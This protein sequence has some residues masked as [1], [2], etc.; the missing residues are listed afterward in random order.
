MLSSITNVNFDKIK[1]PFFI[2]KPANLERRVEYFLNNFSGETLYAVKA[3]PSNFILKKLYEL[4]IKSFDVAS[5]NEIILVKTLFEDANIYFMNAIKPRYAISEAYFKYDV[6]HFSL[7]TNDELEKILEST[8]YANDL[9]LHLRVPVSN[10][11]SVIKL[12]EKFG[13]DENNSEELL[14]KIK[15]FSKKVGICFHVGSQCMSPT[16]YKL[17]INKVA[18]LIKKSNV[19]IDY[20]NIGGGFPSKYVGMDPQP[21]SKYLNII[22]SE[23]AKHLKKNTKIILLSEPGRVLVSNSMSLVV[24]V[25]LRKKNKLYINDG[26]HGYLYNSGVHGFIHSMKIFKKTSESKLSSFSLYGPTCDSND[27]ISGPF[28]LPD[29]INEGDYIEIDE[30]GAYSITMKNNFN[31]FFSS[32]KVFI[33]KANFY[34]LISNNKVNTN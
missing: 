10:D 16:T 4:G 32:P 9:N 1:H 18:S 27:F 2:Y 13:V 29:S 34:N 21:L 25:D 33:K 19:E 6:R 5:V 8:N 26:I 20:L 15:N 14:K 17:A 11:F 28:L 24:R 31:G 22:N 7:D 30:M 23:F 3:N 12:T